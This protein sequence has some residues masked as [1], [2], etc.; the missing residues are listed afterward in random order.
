MTLEQLIRLQFAKAPQP[1]VEYVVVW[2][3]VLDRRR[4]TFSLNGRESGHSQLHDAI[5]R[6]ESGASGRNGKVLR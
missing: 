3:G 4:E 1:R 5:G 6:S 2:S